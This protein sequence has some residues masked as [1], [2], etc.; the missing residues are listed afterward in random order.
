MSLY[1]FFHSS[2]TVSH[3]KTELFKQLTHLER[4]VEGNTK[5]VQM[6]YL[7]FLTLMFVGNQQI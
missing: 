6:F 5:I 1:F 3:L 7:I 2:F 4:K